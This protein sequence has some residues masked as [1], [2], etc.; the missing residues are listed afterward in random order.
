MSFLKVTFSTFALAAVL[1]Q[2]PMQSAKADGGA[3]A[4][5]VGAYLVVDYAVGR[6]CHMHKWPLNIIKKV[7]YGIHGKR[8]CKYKH[9]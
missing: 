4:V 7:A 9:R 1:T 5:A 8:I 6:K 3:T 2:A